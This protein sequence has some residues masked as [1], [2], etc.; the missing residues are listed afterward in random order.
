MTRCRPDVKPILDELRRFR[1]AFAFRAH[2]F[3]GSHVLSSLRSSGSAE[4]NVEVVAVREFV[5][6]D[7]IK[8]TPGEVVVIIDFQ[9][10]ATAR[11]RC[12]WL[13]GLREKV[14]EFLD[15]GCKILLF[16]EV[17]ALELLGCPGSSLITDA[18]KVYIPR[19]E[20]SRLSDAASDN[21]Y[22]D[23][24]NFLVD[25]AKGTPVLANAAMDTIEKSEDRARKTLYEAVRR[26]ITKDLRTA[27]AQC[28]PTLASLLYYY[29]FE[30]G[31]SN[32]GFEEVDPL[33]MELCRAAGMAESG[34]GWETMELFPE[35]HR[36]VW[37]AALLDYVANTVEVPRDFDLVSGGL[38]RIERSLRLLLRNAAKRSR[39]S[40]WKGALPG[41]V[42]DRCL[43]RS[44]E[45]AFPWAT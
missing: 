19:V 29:V 13:G 38:W 26:H 23:L 39:G 4:S 42:A 15:S 30:T 17:P 27:V 36:E 21:G 32:V 31:Q 3:D 18:V 12:E 2:L 8:A 16:S 7:A 1:L 14:T 37:N 40:N 33:V 35:P 6:S 34:D 41:V 25:V 11:D 5:E 45:D 44:Q 10:L 43:R 20:E 9:R 28:G 22:P 24:T